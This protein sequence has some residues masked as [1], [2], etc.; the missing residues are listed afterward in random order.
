MRERTRQIMALLLGFL[1]GDAATTQG[2]NVVQLTDV[3]FLTYD[4]AFE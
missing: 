3:R 1:C 2:W 4:S